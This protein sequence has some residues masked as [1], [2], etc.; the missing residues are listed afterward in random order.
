MYRHQ[1]GGNSQDRFRE[2]MK[3]KNAYA[4]PVGEEQKLLLNALRHNAMKLDWEGAVSVLKQIPSDAGNEWMPVFRSVLNICCKAY[5]PEEAKMVFSQLPQRDVMCYNMLINL[6]GKM[7]QPAVVEDLLQQMDRDKI[8]R[9][10]VTY[11][12]LI[13]GF[14]ET[15]QWQQAISTLA[16]LKGKPELDLPVGSRDAVKWGMAYLSTMSA[17]ARSG[18]REKTRELFETLRNERGQADLMPW[19]YNVLMLSCKDDGP[20]AKVIFDE[21]RA[22]GVEPRADDW[23]TLLSCHRG[24]FEEPRKLYEEFAQESP[25]GPFEELWISLLR[26][27]VSLRDREAGLWVLQEMRARGV[28]P[29]SD[30][31]RTHPAMRRAL[32]QARPLIDGPRRYERPSYRDPGVQHPSSAQ[33]GLQRPATAATAAAPTPLPVPAGW[34]SAV[35]PSSGLEYYWQDA[36][37]AGTTT[38]ARPE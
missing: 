21:M 3:T 24:S 23:K 26:T 11:I 14:A 35:D 16:E 29:D 33:P 34:S 7:A 31:A 25:E 15:S 28:E 17:C 1:L 6:Y 30:R 13:S 12:G 32:H 27:A 20:A 38:W 2:A 4:E 37:P 18:E 22:S 9:S 8:S 36:N 19:H 5:R 10:G